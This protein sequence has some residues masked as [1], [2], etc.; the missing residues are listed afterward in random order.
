MKILKKN[1]YKI[2]TVV[3]IVG[4]IAI[5]ASHQLIEHTAEGF[6]YSDVNDVPHKRVG[7]LLGCSRT[8]RDGRMNLFFQNRINAAVLLFNTGKVDNIIVSGD[9]S[10]SS[11]DEPTEMKNALVARGIPQENIFCDYAGFRTLDSVVRAKHIF[12]A[13]DLV[14]ISQEFHNKRAIFIAQHNGVA[15]VGFNAAEVNVVHSFKT[16]TRELLAKVK[17]ILDIYIL[18]TEPKFYGPVVVIP[19]NQA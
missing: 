18:S 1:V 4:I 14:V 19:K 6:T 3:G 2:L 8:L 13:D 12:R 7:L 16:K 9:N 11:Y 17:T 10:V 5:A 15:A